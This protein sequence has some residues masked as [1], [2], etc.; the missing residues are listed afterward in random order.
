M[1]G[2]LQLHAVKGR[3]DLPLWLV[4]LDGQHAKYAVQ[5]PFAVGVARVGD[6]PVCLIYVNEDLCSIWFSGFTLQGLQSRKDNK[7]IHT[8]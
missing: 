7:T 4:H 1:G 2:G 5:L 6:Q 3:E 8:L